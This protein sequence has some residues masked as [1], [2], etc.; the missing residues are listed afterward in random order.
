M[1][2]GVSGHHI[3]TSDGRLYVVDKNSTNGTYVD[4]VRVEEH[5]L[6]VGN[7]LRFDEFSF[8]VGLP[9]SHQRRIRPLMQPKVMIALWS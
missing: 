8:R 5:L 6:E 2:N 9:L 7:T 1:H 4:D 3:A